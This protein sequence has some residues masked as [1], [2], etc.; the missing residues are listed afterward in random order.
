MCID[1]YGT[2]LLYKIGN[3]R[4]LDKECIIILMIDIE[5]WRN[6]GISFGGI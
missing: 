6:D 4:S 1:D 3:C 2:F 5:V